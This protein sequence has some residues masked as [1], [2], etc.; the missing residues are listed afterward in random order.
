MAMRILAIE[1]SS[2]NRSVAVLIDGVTRGY[3]KVQSGPAT[4]ALGLVDQA[5]KAASVSVEQVDRIAVG[6][7]PGSFTGIRMALALVQGFAMAGRTEVV[8]ISSMLAT[9]TDA[10]LG[11][12]IPQHC[13]VVVDAQRGEFYLGRYE[14]IDEEVRQAGPLQIVGSAEIHQLCKAGERVIATDLALVLPGARPLLPDAVVVGKL[15]ACATCGE[16]V[17]DLKPTYLRQTAFVKCT[18]L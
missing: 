4:P 12:G 10:L 13:H 1:F 18:S 3:A 2:S 9:G 8:G 14:V 6:I 15:G 5:L 17:E 7:G 11:I 16:R